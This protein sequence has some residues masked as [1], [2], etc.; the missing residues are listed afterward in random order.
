[1]NTLRAMA[2]VLAP[3]LTHRLR[4]GQWCDHETYRFRN[5][6]DEVD[7]ASGAI[8]GGAP[9]PDVGWGPWELADLGRMKVRYC[10]RCG[11]MESTHER[12][13]DLVRQWWRSHD[14]RTRRAGRLC[15]IAALIS[16]V[17]IF[18]YVVTYWPMLLVMGALAVIWLIGVIRGWP[19]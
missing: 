1:M 9:A 15:L 2:R 17:T 18:S 19:E 8:T 4:T 6:M 13:V 16:G 7:T 3:R 10:Q 14:R 11:H 12:T 5:W